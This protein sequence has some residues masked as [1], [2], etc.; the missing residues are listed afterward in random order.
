MKKIIL[1]FFILI[2]VKMSAQDPASSQF[3]FNPLYLNPAFAGFNKNARFGTNYRNQW[4]AVPSKFTTYNC[5]GD[6]Y[7]PLF[8]FGFIAMQDV[9]GEGFLKTTSIGFLQSYEIL[10]PKIIRIRTG[11]N[12]TIANKRVDWSKLV[13]SDQLDGLQGQVNT[14]SAVPG[15]ANGKTYADFTAGAMFDLPKIK[16]IPKTT[17]TNT[18]GFVVNHLTQPNDGLSGSTNGMLPYKRTLHYTM[19]V[20]VLKDKT[21]K[22][23]FFISPNFIY[24]K[25]AN[26]TTTNVGVY[27]S[28][29]PMVGGFFYRKRK[30]SDK[31]NDDSFIVFMGI[32]QRITDKLA[33]RIG[34][35]YDFTLNNLASNT[36]GSHELSMVF[37]FANFKLFAKNENVRKRNKR[38]ADCTDF[39]P[40]KDYKG[41]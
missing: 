35:S 28:K 38:V 19:V 16:M 9:S 17:I 14:T 18:F 10:I 40:S 31:K 27:V 1:A 30:F 22:S 2:A 20:E 26:F 34:Y 5:W 3:F 4:T 13:F 25:Q 7:T 11:Y 32:H 41:F 39:G 12:V 8:G 21:Q 6:I 36:L 23:P 37:E 15:N 29:K 33:L 24:E